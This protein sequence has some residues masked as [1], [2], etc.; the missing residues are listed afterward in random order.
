M[1]KTCT[2]YSRTVFITL[3]CSWRLPSAP[4]PVNSRDPCTHCEPHV[5]FLGM[6]DI[7]ERRR[8]CE[9][10]GTE[11]MKDAGYS[12]PMFYEFISQAKPGIRTKFTTDILNPLFWSN[13][14]KTDIFVQNPT[15]F[16]YD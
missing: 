14:F 8:K 15:C 13:D 4:F 9:A 6:N 3:K 5:L 7:F 12:K 10:A 2:L 16:S 1:L 11:W